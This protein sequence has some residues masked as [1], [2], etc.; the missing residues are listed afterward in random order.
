M[1]SKK[2]VKYQAEAY[3]EIWENMPT[4]ICHAD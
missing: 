4:I 3:F 1:S 2:V